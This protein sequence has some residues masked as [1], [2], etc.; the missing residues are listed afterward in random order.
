MDPYIVPSPARREEGLTNNQ[1]ECRAILAAVESLHVGARAEIRSDSEN[2][3][4]QLKGER[5]ILNPQL[6]EL[7]QKINK[8]VFDRELTISFTWIPRRDNLAGKLL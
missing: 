6:E 1:A 8:V 7:I 3:C 4:F 5:R 2:T